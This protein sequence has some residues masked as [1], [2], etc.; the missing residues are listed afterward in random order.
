MKR[1]GAQERI[2]NTSDKRKTD[3]IDIYF[4]LKRAQIRK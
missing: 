4:P 3:K 1:S 2:P